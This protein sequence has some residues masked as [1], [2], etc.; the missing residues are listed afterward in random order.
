MS[1]KPNEKVKSCILLL[2]QTVTEM[3]SAKGKTVKPG[4]TCLVCRQCSWKPENPRTRPRGPAKEPWGPGGFCWNVC[5]WECLAVYPPCSPTQWSEWWNGLVRISVCESFSVYFQSWLYSKALLADFS[6]VISPPPW[7]FQTT[8]IC[9]CTAYL[10]MYCG[11]LEGHKP[12]WCLTFST[13]YSKN[14][15]L[16]PWEQSRAHWECTIYVQVFLNCKCYLNVKLYC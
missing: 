2:R 16:P 11:L 13:P 6:S 5:V 12:M 10:F 1:R 9:R 7:K 3:F 14:L 4:W 15:F 8:D